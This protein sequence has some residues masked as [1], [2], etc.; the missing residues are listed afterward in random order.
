MKSTN[1]TATHKDIID[2]ANAIQYLET[3]NIQTEA[4]ARQHIHI[5]KLE[6][7]AIHTQIAQRSVEVKNKD[8][9]DYDFQEWRRS[10]YKALEIKA[11]QLRWIK[12]HIVPALRAE[13]EDSAW[14]TCITLSDYILGLPEGVNV[15]KEITDKIMQFKASLLK[16]N[17]EK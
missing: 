13:R 10:A 16:R 15:P 5:L 17:C 9:Y 3:L 8:R 12:E 4:E 7:A 11:N 6:R 2:Y 14:K 1:T